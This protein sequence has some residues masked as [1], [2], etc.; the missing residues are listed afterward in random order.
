[1]LKELEPEIDLNEIVPSYIFDIVEMERKI[2]F[3]KE[4]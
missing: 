3:I 4:F 1:M 2:P